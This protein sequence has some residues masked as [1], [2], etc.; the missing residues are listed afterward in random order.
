MQA[1]P[2][3]FYCQEISL[4]TPVLP[5]MA[6]HLTALHP[7]FTLST[8]DFPA[9]AEALVSLMKVSAGEPA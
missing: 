5:A 2:R 4:Q 7:D 1:L 9:K 3:I 8:S 6:A